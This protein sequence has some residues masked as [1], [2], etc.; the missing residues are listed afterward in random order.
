MILLPGA[1]AAS[2]LQSTHFRLDPNVA[3]TFGGTGSSTSYKL[4]DSGGE[5]VVGTGTSTNYKLTQGYVAQLAQ[6]ISLSVLPSGVVAYYPLDTGAGTQAFDVSTNENRG[7]LTNSPSWVAGQV[8]QALS[9]NGTTQY[10]DIPSS[11]S[12]DLTGSSTFEAW[13]K[14]T[15]YL[16]TNTILSKTTSA[17]AA[18][19]TFELRTEVT[20][21]KLQFGGFD[22]AARTVSTSSAVPT[23]VWTH[24]A[25]VKTGGS[26]KLYIGGRL[27][28]Q[29]SV[30]TTATNARPLKLGARDD[31]ANF[32]KG[33]IDDV[34]LYARALTDSEVAGD[35]TA[36]S[37]GLQF[38]HTLPAVTPGTS[39]TYLVDAVVRTDAG[40]Y[41]LYIQT[42]KLPIHTVDGITTFPAMSGTI[43]TPG[44]WTE[45]TTKGLGF[46]VTSGQQI[47]AKWV[48]S[49]YNYAALPFAAT[50]FHART[51]LTGG[52]PEKTTLQFRADSTASQKQ[53]T[54]K[55]AVIYTATI[56]P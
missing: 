2:L 37:N 8:G 25:A 51:G 42:P 50:S 54:Y 30:S 20:T 26:V 32:F 16:N 33:S 56:R 17:G 13:V 4:T 53:G 41:D 9:F 5:A 49:P 52:I 31:L 28:G 39:S 35:F 45:G 14:V 10:V 29:G 22:T 48:G 23:G 38:A 40:G 46:S 15:D 21:G 11:A 7:V 1:A 27:L 18:N 36:G 3:N 6:A 44:T 43:G 19:N 24:V 47:E 55:A 12:I 34:R